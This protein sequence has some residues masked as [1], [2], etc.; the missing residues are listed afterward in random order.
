MYSKC[1]KSLI[2][3]VIFLLAF[4]SHGNNF[5]EQASLVLKKIDLCPSHGDSLQVY[6]GASDY[7]G[8]YRS[9]KCG[10]IEKVKKI[11]ERRRATVDVGE[12]RPRTKETKKKE[13]IIKYLFSF[14]KKCKIT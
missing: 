2:S 6:L 3:D 12:K 11:E 9:E 14:L 8:F 13:K 1:L 10:K 4:L 5:F 7:Y